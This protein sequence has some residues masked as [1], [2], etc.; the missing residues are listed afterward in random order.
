MFNV[1]LVHDPATPSWRITLNIEQRARLGFGYLEYLKGQSPEYF[2]TLT[3]RYSYGDRLAEDGMRGFVL[4]LI[5]RMP[6]HAR[7]N[8]G[9][10]VC[11]ERHTD[12]KF[13]GAYHFH[14][15]FWGL[16]KSMSDAYDWLKANVVRAASELHP[17][18]PG[19]RCDCSEAARQGRPQTCKG[20]LSCRGPRMSGANWVDVQQIGPSTDACC[21]YLID[22]VHRTD[23]AAGGQLL[24]IDGTGVTGRMM[25]RDL[26]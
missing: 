9:G 5:N 18:T 3:Y 16:N 24:T 21:A 6:R 8:F 26:I 19:P 22:D 10:L 15:L 17:R 1:Q 11:A 20:G 4:K 7:R 14:F 23:R 2:V 25:S 13:D 12:S